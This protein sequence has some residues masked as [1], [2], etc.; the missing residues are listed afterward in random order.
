MSFPLRSLELY[1]LIQFDSK[2]SEEY[3]FGDRTFIRKG[4]RVTYDSYAMDQMEDVWGPDCL[5]FKTERWLKNGIFFACE[6]FQV[7]D[8]SS[9]DLF[10]AKEMTLVEMNSA[11]VAPLRWLY[12]Y[13]LAGCLWRQ[14]LEGSLG[15]ITIS[16]FGFLILLIPH[17]NRSLP[18]SF[19]CLIEPSLFSQMR[20]SNPIPRNPIWVF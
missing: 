7:S 9:W 8:F 6:S 16:L 14:M 1:L 5:E 2:F 4:K 17:S 15:L 19:Y 12:V 13:V 10:W 20:C 11:A 3:N 18:Y